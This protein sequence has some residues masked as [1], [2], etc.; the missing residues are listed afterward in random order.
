MTRVAHSGNSTTFE[1][2]DRIS[3]YAWLGAD[4]DMQRL[5][6]D[7][8]I[9]TLGGDGTWTADPQ[10]LWADNTSDH[11]FLG[12]YPE[13]NGA[14][15]YDADPYTLDF[16][17][18][19]ASD[20]LVARTTAKPTGSAVKLEFEH[21]MAK[22]VVNLSFRNEWTTAPEVASV[23]ATACT[24]ATVNYLENP[25]E[26]TPATGQNLVVIP[27]TGTSASFAGIMIPGQSGF[28]TIN[29]T[30]ENGKVYTYT[31]SADIDLQPGRYTTVNLVLG[32]DRIELDDA[33]INVS[34]WENGTSID[35]AEANEAYSYDSN[36]K[37]I[38][39]YS[40]EG[41]KV[42]ADVVN[43]GDNDINIILDNDIDLS[44]ID[45]TPIG[46]ESRPYTG[47]FDGGT[48]TITGLT[49]NQTREN[50]GL[51]GCIGSNGTVKNVK[52]ENVNIT[53]DGYFVGGVAGTNYGTIEN[54]S[55]DGTLTNNRH[56]LGGVVGNNY[57][58]IIG[59]SSSGTITGTS[60]NVG[61]IGG[62]SVGGTIMACYSVANIKG[63]SSSGGVLGQTNRET[64]VIACYHAK[65][66][67]TGEQ[68]R[69]IGGVIGWNYGKV[70]ACYWENNQGQGIGDNQGSTTIE[71]TKVDGTDV[72]WQTAVAAMNT[73]LQSAGSGWHY[74]LNGALP[75]LEEK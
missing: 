72:T 65:G 42:A 67:V 55:V 70:T 30:L 20:L 7:N 61:G 35:G 59:C 40:G 1:T 11:Y 10:M 17:N 51:I 48:Y 41:L 49:V 5:V 3:V 24:E 63:W 18:Q 34:D 74:V 62:Q 56:Y 36:T 16:N 33:G 39:I 19:T 73:A 15:D 22:L 37:T 21:V 71:T 38:T 69:M 32:R 2:N 52:L 13:R 29:V 12:I 23:T 64:V 53:G 58:S 26:V 46:T 27:F 14:T 25:V 43:S 28:R 54:C 44:D 75:T 4:N 50:V 9:N 8:S 31:H 60:P 57:G 45:W 68:S 66:N 6:V 47:T